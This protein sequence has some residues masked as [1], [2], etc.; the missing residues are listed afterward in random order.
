MNSKG[1]IHIIDDEPVIR[2]VLAQLLTSEGYEVELSASGEEALEKFPSP[3][4]RRHPP[5]PAH[6]G[7]GRDRGPAAHQ[8]DR[9]PGRR[10]SSSPPTARSNRPSRP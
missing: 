4:L 8:A 10:S 9:S 3:V 2:D 6:A 5:R 1:I 7:D